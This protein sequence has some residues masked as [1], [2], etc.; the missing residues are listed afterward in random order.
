MAEEAPARRQSTIFDKVK[1]NGDYRELFLWK[2]KD[3]TREQVNDELKSFTQHNLR[4]TGE[5]DE[6]EA[7]MLLE[8]RGCAKTA[9][10]LRSCL[11]EIDKDQSHTVNFLEWLCFWF[12]KSYEDLNDF[13]D[14]DARE[15]AFAEAMAA[16]I[17]AQKAQDAIEAAKLAEEEA[18][19]KRAAEIEA[20]SKLTGVAGATAFFKRRAD[21]SGDQTLS[22]EEKIKA[23][24]A[25][26]RELRDAQKAQAAALQSALNHRS[27]E[28]VA[29]ELVKEKMRNA[30]E[31][32]AAE[33]ERQAK[34]RADRKARKEA[35]NAAFLAKVNSPPK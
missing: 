26:R 14:E 12:K 23:E 11:V 29:K 18:A 6:H 2:Y 8:H 5:L 17:A 31:E 19:R 16:G 4:K 10:E 9:V 13:V 32:A 34:E 15:R 20:E 28:E 3:I 24:A 25:R 21:E 27:A 35:L 22:N 1:D 30:A 7:M 33:A